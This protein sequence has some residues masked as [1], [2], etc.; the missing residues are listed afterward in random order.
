MSLFSFIKCYAQYEFGPIFAIDFS[1][2]FHCSKLIGIYLFSD[3]LFVSCLFQ[4][5]IN[6][7]SLENSQCVV[8]VFIL[9]EKRNVRKNKE[10]E[11]KEKS[12]NNLNSKQQEQVNMKTCARSKN[13]AIYSV[14]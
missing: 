12:A 14:K 2:S 11:E 5:L 8:F 1:L 9:G 7:P 6:F 10:K 13:K 3:C 4:K